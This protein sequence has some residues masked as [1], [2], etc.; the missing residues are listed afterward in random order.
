MH[1]YLANQLTLALTPD[2]LLRAEWVARV[3]AL[4]LYV[5]ELVAQGMKETFEGHRKRSTAFLRFQLSNEVLLRIQATTL[6]EAASSAYDLEI[7][8]RLGLMTYQEPE[9][10]AEG[11][12]LI[13]DVS[14]WTSIATSQGSTPATMDNDAK[15][16]KRGLSLIVE[17][18][19]KIAHEGDLQPNVPRTP[20]P[21]SQADLQYVAGFIRR[22]VDA[23]DQ[24]V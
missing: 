3:S 12:R 22:I 15:V 10:I 23:I 5:H 20:W 17:R 7:R 24:I 11:I 13:S 1:A 21:I 8:S 6:P 16:A 9:K 18:R 19:N 2:E 4:D 14:L